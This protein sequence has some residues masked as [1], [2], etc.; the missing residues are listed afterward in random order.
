MREDVRAARSQARG[1]IGV[2]LALPAF[3]TLL[4]LPSW[5]GP[6]FWGSPQPQSFVLAFAMA[7]Y[8]VGL[9]WMVRIYRR[10]HL[11][12]EMSTWRYREAVL[13]L[14]LPRRQHLTRR[15]V[16][17]LMIVATALV[18]VAGAIV[19]VAQ[20]GFTG[21]DWYQ[22][23]YLAALP[24]TGWTVYA[25]GLGWMIRIYRRSHLEPESDHWRYRS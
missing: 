16:A 20:P 7:V 9:G 10:S 8:L 14:D 17:R 15:A 3:V 12:P 21:G 22:P 25:I 6:L 2:A 4:W 23:W 18:P 1:L 19:S 11:E 13:K 24:W 5:F